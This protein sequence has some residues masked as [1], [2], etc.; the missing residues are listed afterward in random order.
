M[1]SLKNAAS[2]SKVVQD[3][4]KEEV[5]NGTRE[6]LITALKAI[7]DADKQP[8]WKTA[9]MQEL[10]GEL[11]QTH[12]G[13]TATVPEG[14]A[15]PAAKEAGAESAEM[16][17]AGDAVAEAAAADTRLEDAHKASPAVKAQVVPNI[18]NNMN[19]SQ[20]R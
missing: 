20:H 3:L 6:V 12:A 19:G 8:R 2:T 16:A 10:A 1:I 13:F 14:T 18:H 4:S 11:M 7:G 17:A 15:N 5:E 9:T